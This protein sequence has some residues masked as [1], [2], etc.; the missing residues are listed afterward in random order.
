MKLADS[1]AVAEEDVFGGQECKVM[2]ATTGSILKHT[3]QE[4][5]KVAD[6]LANMGF[7]LAYQG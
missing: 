5:Y 2:M 4:K 7:F 1:G 3:L 6:R